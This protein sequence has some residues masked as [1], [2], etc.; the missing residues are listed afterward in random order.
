MISQAVIRI[1]RVGAQKL[2]FNGSGVRSSASVRQCE[3]VADGSNPQFEPNS[4]Y[5]YPSPS[6]RPGPFWVR[7]PF[8]RKVIHTKIRR[9][10]AGIKHN[11][12]KLVENFHRYAHLEAI[13]QKQQGVGACGSRY[14]RFWVYRFWR[15]APVATH[16]QN[17]GLSA[18]ELARAPQSCLMATLFWVLQLARLGMWHF[19][20]NIRSAAALSD[21]KLNTGP[22][23]APNLNAV[24][25]YLR[26][27]FA[28]A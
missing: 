7:P 9:Q 12:V 5:R 20:R 1:R 6:L 28:H 26:T 13:K 16:T 25:S 17:K 27:A 22:R 18:Q 11:F 8:S 10:Y 19:A 4:Y 24:R 3:F 2:P 23:K 21:V 15:W 14:L